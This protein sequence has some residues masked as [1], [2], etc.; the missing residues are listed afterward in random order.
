MISE[1]VNINWSA[2]NR[3]K[4]IKRLEEEEFE[5]V[6]IGGGVTG[7]GIAREAALRGIKTAL[8]DKNDF[9]FGTS[10]RS[11]KM[12]HGGFRYLSQNEF[13]IVRESTTE[14]NWLRNHFSHNVRPLMTNIGGFT[15]KKISPTEV[16]YGLGIYDF[17]SNFG[18]KFKQYRKHKILS[19]EEVS[20]EEPNFNLSGLEILGQYYDTNIDDSRL[21]LE[22]IKESKIIGDVVALNYVKAEDFILNDLGKIIRLKVVDIETGKKFEIK[23]NQF[24]NAT[25]IWTDTLLRNYPRKVIR[26]TK[27]VHIVV[28]GD[29]IGNNHA[30][31]VFRMDDRRSIFILT[32]NEFTIVGTTD[33]DYILGEKGKPNEDFDLPYCTK[34]DCDY[35][36]ETVN[37]YFP[38]ANL[39]YND[40]ISTFAGIRPLVMEEGKSESDISRKEVI[41]DTENG[42]TSICGG[43]L[44]TFRLMAENTLYHIIKK[45]NGFIKDGQKREFPKMQLKP[46]YSKQEYLIDLKRKEW[47]Q[48]INDYKS[49][50]AEDTTNILYQ[51][52]GRGAIEIVKDVLT[53]PQRGK[54]FLNEVQFI[55]AEIYYI[56][57]HEFAPHLIDVLTRRTEIS[58]K[59]HH[60]KQPEIAEKIANI[61]A[62]VYGWDE[63]TKKSEIKQYIDHI[64]RTIWF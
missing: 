8:I 62:D 41:L 34:E 18:T 11:S 22:T 20:I 25:G 17:L 36:I 53:N 31:G 52:Y 14:R 44:T 51:Q 6:I 49:K 59:V 64:G 46:G 37:Q 1:I 28:P 15:D 47:D 61:M 42:L 43:K 13:K 48:F 24:I 16:K 3:N 38:S 50:L 21:T 32:R 45:K 23:S 40:I 57:S 9:G 5:L 58:M 60:K 35:L 2:L 39:N 54:R 55:P 63:T 19:R 10:S 12:A 4:D 30:F 7:A 29:R 56:L 26:P 27:G 33:T